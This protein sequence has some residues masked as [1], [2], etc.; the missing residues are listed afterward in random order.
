MQTFYLQPLV[1]VVG[2]QTVLLGVNAAGNMAQADLNK[3][4][5]LGPDSSYVLCVAGDDIEG[6]VEAIAA[7][8][9]AGGRSYG[10]VNIRGRRQVVVTVG[11]CAVGAYVVAGTAVAL[12]V[13]GPINV[14]PG[15]GVKFLWR[16]VSTLGGAGGVASSVV[17][18]RINA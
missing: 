7:A 2:N 4:V 16:V 3:P 1:D 8:K 5:K 13:V 15:A 17:I 18:E 11:A 12:G 14:Q 10:T 6:T 9:V